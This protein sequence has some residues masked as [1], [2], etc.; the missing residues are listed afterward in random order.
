MTTE[1]GSSP[2][3]TRAIRSSSEVWKM[4]RES[5]SGLTIATRVRSPDSAMLLEREARRS[6]APSP[7]PSPSPSSSSPPPTDPHAAAPATSPAVS[8]ILQTIEAIGE[9]GPMRG[10]PLEKAASPHEEEAPLSGSQPLMEAI[11]KI[12]EMLW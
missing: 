9:Y 1:D 11:N 12:Y 6:T 7:S 5:S 10:P 3:A 4:D 2:V 8:V